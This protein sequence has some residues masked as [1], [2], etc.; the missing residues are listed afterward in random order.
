LAFL[1]D[2]VMGKDYD[3][4]YFEEALKEAQEKCLSKAPKLKTSHR[5]LFVAACQVFYD[6]FEESK[7]AATEQEAAEGAKAQQKAM[8]KCVKAANKIF[9]KLDMAENEKYE[10]AMLK[11]AVI[12]QATPAGLA[13][14]S[15]Q[16]KKNGKVVDHL[17]K[18]PSL[19]KEMLMYGGAA[20][21][22]YGQA[23][24]IYTKILAG[25]PEED[26]Q[27]TDVNRKIAMAVALELASPIT[28]F[29]TKVEV[30]PFDRYKHYESAYK[31]GELDPAF[32]H[33]TIW[34]LR[35]V[36]NCD[37][38]NDQLAWAR[39][40][41]INYSP[42]QT[43]LTD[44]KQRYLYILETDV[45]MRNPSWTASPRTYQQVL[46]G[47]GKDGPNA[48]FGRF[49]CKAHGIPTWGCKQ[50][51]R[52]ALT[53]WTP[54]GW[55]A[56]Q[57]AD[58]DICA[59]N[60]VSGIDFKGEVDARSAHSPEQYYSKLVLLECMAE[61]MDGRRGEI[62]EEELTI[63]HPNR[64]WRSLAIIQKALM[65]EPASPESF[66]RS[67]ESGVKTWGEQYLDIYNKD[68][69]DNTCTVEGDV[70]T[71]PAGCKGFHD[72][73]VMLIASFLG[74][75]QLNFLADGVVEFEVPDVAYP[76][77]YTLKLLV[78]T[79]H[80][81][82]SPL[83]LKIDEDDEILIEVPYTV[84]EWQETKGVEVELSG[85]KIM[86]FKRERPSFGLAIKK[87]MLS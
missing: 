43:T 39:R 14:F 21:G 70:I 54:T 53:R 80:L 82:Q 74:G 40:M 52:T 57:G 78:N 44:L 29:D 60:G 56:M 62:S 38:P 64:V 84:G 10:A 58:W 27:Y 23:M 83:K 61:V 55:E 67:G 35:H 48:W 72:G 79:V 37:A 12:T 81:K 46:S 68:E 87:L 22:K 86:R 66:E 76:K 34:E 73:N 47:G 45:L 4:A 49:I 15:S 1:D 77:K 25:F 8:K 9:E 69:P 20:E 33:F 50:K 31:N 6:A 7:S 18:S 13:E 36:I 3:I 28:E 26:D 63:L 75:L 5:K 85:G 42:Y 17:L 24:K 32:P 11:G 19:M 65:L 30:D 59:W 71:I 2:C 41:L 51:G 16:D